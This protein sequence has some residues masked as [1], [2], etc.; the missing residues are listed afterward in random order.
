MKEID[1]KRKIQNQPLFKKSILENLATVLNDQSI[2]K[3]EHQK[4]RTVYLLHNNNFEQSFNVTPDFSDEK[5]EIIIEIVNKPSDHVMKD[6]SYI[7]RNSALK[8]FIL[9]CLA[10]N[11]IE[12]KN[13]LNEMTL[14]MSRYGHRDVL[15][16][17]VNID[18]TS[19]NIEYKH[20]T[21]EIFHS[22]DQ[23]ELLKKIENGENSRV[24]LSVLED[25]YSISRN[26]QIIK[27][28]KK[29]SIDNSIDLK[30]FKSLHENLIEDF[31]KKNPH[32]DRKLLKKPI[33][34][35]PSVAR[36]ENFVRNEEVVGRKNRRVLKS[37]LKAPFYLTTSGGGIRA[38]YD[39][40]SHHVR[41][42]IKNSIVQ[43][44]K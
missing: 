9:V 24:S 37:F 16:Y 39:G 7:C 40:E 42:G 25:V 15:L 4:E 18:P 3:C 14:L 35:P 32:F 5:V 26:N 17:V 28:C 2:L 23:I 6:Y 10:S 1:L 30:T 19:A 34:I 43:K 44:R 22:V 27:F 8:K 11:S 38:V 29:Y 20:D 36:A 41:N 31:F 13:W 33:I 12:R 21:N